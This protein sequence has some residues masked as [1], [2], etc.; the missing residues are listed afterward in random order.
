MQTVS[1]GDNLHEMSKP[2]LWENKKNISVCRLLKILPRVLSLKRNDYNFRGGKSDKVI[3]CL[4]SE[5]VYDLLK[6]KEF[7]YLKIP[8]GAKSFLLQPTPFQ[9]GFDC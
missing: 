4:L 1:I 2:V 8:F 9:M 3:I 6:K 7:A 5:K